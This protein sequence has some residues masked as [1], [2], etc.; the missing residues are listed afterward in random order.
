MEND[1]KGHLFASNPQLFQELYN[2]GPENEEFEVEEFVPQTED[3]VQRM[4][5][6]LKKEGVIH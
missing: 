1:F 3:D 5:M 4:L 6:Q 2:A